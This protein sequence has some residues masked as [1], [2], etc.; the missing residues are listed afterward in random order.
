MRAD[1]PITDVRVSAYE[2]PTE[3]P[4]S[5]GTLEWDSTT[6]VLCEVAAGGETGIGW[7]YTDVS[8]ALL[9]EGK[10]GPLLEGRDALAVGARWE[11]MLAATRNLGRPGMVSTAI[12]ACDVALHDLRGRL[13][14]A[15]L[16]D[17]LGRRRDAVA[18]YGSGGFT[19]Y[20]HEKLA[21]Q[22]RGWAGAGLPAVKMKIGRDPADDPARM[23][24]ARAAIGTDCDLFVDANGAY[25]RKQALAMAAHAADL[26]VTWFEEPVS[27]NDLDGMRLLRDAGPPGVEIT[28]GEYGYDQVYFRRMLEAGAV[29]VLQPDA[30]RCAGITGFLAVAALAEAFEV[31]ISSHTAPALHL[32]A[33]CAAP[34]LRHM[35]WF[36]DHV[37]IEAMFFDGAPEPHEGRVAPDL[38]RPGLG[39]AFRRQDAE[40]YRVWPRGSA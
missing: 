32:H 1:S 25:S 15:P 17:L 6:L 34:K 4:E 30:T 5:D 35:E 36:F 20:D 27:S 26:G 33:A 13:M 18:L 23:R 31:P 14:R 11:D 19:N 16:A 39:L 21:D 2:V 10:L 38:A 28:S 24:T 9:I 7:S 8:A 22:A 29:D 37:R 12:A 40:R 3:T